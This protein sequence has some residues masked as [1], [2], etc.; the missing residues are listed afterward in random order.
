MSLPRRSGVGGVAG[1]K[2]FADSSSISR[3]TISACGGMPAETL[4]V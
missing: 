3:V 4:A 2:M 1:I